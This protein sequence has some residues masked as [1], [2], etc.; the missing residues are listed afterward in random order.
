MTRKIGILGCGHV[1]STIAHQIIIEGITD[2]LVLIDPDRDKLSADLL[3]F[4]DAQVNLSYHTK[5][6]ANDYSALSDADVVISAF[7]NI[8]KAWETPTDRFAEFPY[9]KKY[10]EEA[11]P[12]LKASAFKGVL[13]VVSNPCDVI[14]SIFQK[15]TELP[16]DQV[17]GTGT[18]LDSSR[19]KRAT[20][21]ALKI[22]PRSVIGYSL[23]EHGNSQFVAWSTVR[24]LGK[25]IKKILKEGAYPNADLERI[26]HDSKMGGHI[27]FFGKHYT[28][29][30]ISAA[31]LR[32][33]KAVLNDAHEELPVSNYYQPLDTYLGYPAIIGRKGI[34]EQLQLDLSVDERTKLKQS[35]DFI[36]DKTKEALKKNTE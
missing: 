28:N 19:M 11:A 16:K 15:I 8:T 5:L 18:L 33:L 30:G 1:G 23:G 12:R 35:D 2:T 24:V 9:T 13:I 21:A 7:G 25:P 31:A 29:Y 20:A 6:I 17:I 27:V 26:D 34:I 14:T 3:D 10:V 4:Q 36:K 22:D 32:L